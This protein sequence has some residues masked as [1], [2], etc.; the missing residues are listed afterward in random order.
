MNCGFAD[1]RYLSLSSG[2]VDLSGRRTA[3]APRHTANVWTTY[4]LPSGLGIGGGP[5]LV[6][7][8]FT[9][10]FNDVPV[11]RYTTW[12][13]AVFFRRSL[14]DIA[15]NVNNVL[16][17]DRYFLGALYNTQ[18]NPGPPLNAFVTFRVRARWPKRF[19]SAGWRRR[20]VTACTCAAPRPALASSSS[21]SVG[22]PDYLSALNF[23]G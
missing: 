9:N 22:A 14:W 7:S 4:D 19:S 15:L 6:G 8:R 18:L 5:R 17:E 23:S 1:S 3:F 20:G 13:A 12:D 21:P 10:F 11:A 16:D 2:G